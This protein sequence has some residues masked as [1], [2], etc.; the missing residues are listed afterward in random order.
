MD[1]AARRRAHALCAALALCAGC[2][3]GSKSP[4]D[5][6]GTW[7]GQVSGVGKPVGMRFT[8][9]DGN[10]VLTGQTFVQDPKTGQFLRDADLTGSRQG[11]D[12]TWAISDDVLV[13]GRFE[14]SGFSGTI[15][16]RLQDPDGTPAPYVAKLELKR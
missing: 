3:S 10:G 6:S 12:A 1:G 4:A 11:A 8:L 7:Q 15:E 5:L 16:F 14:G 2:G 13:A 9:Q